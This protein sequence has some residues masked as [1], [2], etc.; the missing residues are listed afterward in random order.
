MFLVP[1]ITTLLCFLT[2]AACLHYLLSR[3]G[4]LWV[5]PFSISG[6]FLYI[7]IEPLMRVATG[8]SNGGDLV[9]IS[10]DRSIAEVIPLIIVILWY[11]M[12]M[13]FHLTLKY[14]MP[15]NRH[16]SYTRKNLHETRY[17]ERVE[18][19][20]MKRSIRRRTRLALRE[21]RNPKGSFYPL[22]W[23]ALFDE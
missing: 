14:V 10:P 2:C 6:L 19:K 18:T 13:I 4:W 3:Q 9:R 21:I 23:V 12:V 7:S 15:V 1:I 16:L 20:M 22:D 5:L 17:I 11:L 8:L